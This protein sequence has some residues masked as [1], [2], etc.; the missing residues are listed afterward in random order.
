[1]GNLSLLKTTLLYLKVT[2]ADAFSVMNNTACN[3]LYHI[4]PS[5]FCEDLCILWWYFIIQTIWGIYFYFSVCYQSFPLKVSLSFFFF[6]I[7]WNFIFYFVCNTLFVFMRMV[8]LNWR[9]FFNKIFFILSCN[10]TQKFYLKTLSNVFTLSL[11]SSLL[12]L[13][14]WYVISLTHFQSHIL[15]WELEKCKIILKNIKSNLSLSKFCRTIY[16]NCRLC[17]GNRCLW[18]MPFVPWQA[19]RHERSTCI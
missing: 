15:K 18:S 7:T 5:F 12:M 13:S 2:N 4:S 9:T 17:I 10:D 11:I 6:L 3:L 19:C 16:T 1:M 8:A 14:C